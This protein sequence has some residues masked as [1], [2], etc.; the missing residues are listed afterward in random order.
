MVI[1]TP[2]NRPYLHYQYDVSYCFDLII[3]IIIII[4]IKLII[5]FIHDHH[6]H[7]HFQHQC[8]HKYK[9]HYHYH[10]FHPCYSYYH[11]IT[12]ILTIILNLPLPIPY[13]ASFLPIL[14]R[15]HLI[16]SEREATPKAILRRRC[17]SATGE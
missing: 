10:L 15:Q 16:S 14:P 8:Q 11:I 5:V 13:L 3:I 17:N 12:S 4:L 7:Y 2:Y 6:F 1:I 9:Y